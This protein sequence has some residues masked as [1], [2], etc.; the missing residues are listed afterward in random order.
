MIN[1]NELELFLSIMYN[2]KYNI[3]NLSMGQWFDIQ[4]YASIWQFL[5]MYALTKQEIK[6]LQIKEMNDP[7]ATEMFQ[8][9]E[10]QQHKCYNQL[11]SRIHE[12]DSE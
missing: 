6:N 4:S 3:Y 1:P 7:V 9:Y 10:I 11:L 5:E 12:E 2:P 8:A